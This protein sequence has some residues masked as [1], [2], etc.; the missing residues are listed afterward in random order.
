MTALEQ[1]ISNARAEYIKT[2][3]FG[4]ISFSSFRG[5]HS[6]DLSDARG[7]A[8]FHTKKEATA[9]LKN[10]GG[11]TINNISRFHTRFSCGWVIGQEI[12]DGEYRLITE[13]DVAGV[14]YAD[15][16]LNI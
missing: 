15:Y 12:G 7:Y 13:K 9:A 1:S 8:I 5:N 16:K 11:W 3:G 6:L 4:S 14:G 10:L 2:N